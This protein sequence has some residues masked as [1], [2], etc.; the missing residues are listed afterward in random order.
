MVDGLF[1]MKILQKSHHLLPWLTQ[2]SV[3]AAN[4]GFLASR[5][6]QKG[7]KLQELVNRLMNLRRCYKKLLNPES[8]KVR[9]FESPSRRRARFAISTVSSTGTPG[10]GDGGA[11]SE[12]LAPGGG[13]GGGGP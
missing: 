8:G 10:G 1:D 4:R 13:G 9:L 7:A 12:R 11:W 2:Y 6:M 5:W 3:M